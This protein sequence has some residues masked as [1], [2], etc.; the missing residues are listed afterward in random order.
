MSSHEDQR[1]R[2][3]V[4]HADFHKECKVIDICVPLDTNAELR[5]M[6]KNDDYIHLVDQL[7]RIYPAYKYCI[8]PVIV[9]TL[10]TVTKTFKDIS[11]KIGLKKETVPAVTERIQKL[12]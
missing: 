2:N 4:R 10:G 6:T 5:H 1:D 7:Q 3:M 9:G 11:L 12:G 8:I